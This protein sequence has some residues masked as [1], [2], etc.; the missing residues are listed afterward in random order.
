M[1]ERIF[2]INGEED[3]IFNVGLG[4]NLIGKA[5]DY[6]IKLHTT[7]LI[8]K[9]Q[10]R[11]IASGFEESIEQFRQY[12]E[13]RDIRPGKDGHPPYKVSNMEEYDAY[14]I[15]FTNYHESFWAEQHG[16]T[17]VIAELKLSNMEKQ[18]ALILKSF[19]IMITSLKSIDRKLP[20]VE[21]SE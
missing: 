1:V 12:I 16:R 14:N 20:S 17:R 13:N 8:D 19:E 4:S 18:L 15:N 11:I 10:V 9:K 6:N 7:N 5:G 21:K 2:F 3:E